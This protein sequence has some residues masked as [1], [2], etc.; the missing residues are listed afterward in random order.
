MHRVPYS[1]ART[2]CTAVTRGNLP[3]IRVSASIASSEPL[4]AVGGGRGGALRHGDAADG[5]LVVRHLAQE[6][7][8][9]LRPHVEELTT[10]WVTCSMSARFLLAGRPSRISMCTIGI[11]TLPFWRRA[12]A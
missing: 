2:T 3:G 10:A 12:A 4:A 8:H 11:A 7:A 1:N 6:H 9:L 5:P